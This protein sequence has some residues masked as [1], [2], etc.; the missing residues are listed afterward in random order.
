MVTAPVAPSGREPRRAGALVSRDQPPRDGWQWGSPLE[1][2]WRARG[3]PGRRECGRSGAELLSRGRARRPS[4]PRAVLDRLRGTLAGAP[5][6]S[7]DEAALP[8]ALSLRGSFYPRQRLKPLRALETEP[9]PPHSLRAVAPAPSDSPPTPG[10]GPVRTT[11]GL[12][13]PCVPGVPGDRGARRAHA[14]CP[15][16]PGLPGPRAQQPPGTCCPRDPA[17]LVEGQSPCRGRGGGEPRGCLRRPQRPAPRASWRPRS[18]CASPR[19]L[20]VAQP[21]VWWPR[22]SPPRP[23]STASARDRGS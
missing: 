21:R 16:G 13:G 4:A 14:G 7:P 2:G 10:R 15:S 9:R 19:L 12:P 20:L 6:W 17:A 3:V 8:S 1:A 23:G 5:P 11:W 18:G 22:P